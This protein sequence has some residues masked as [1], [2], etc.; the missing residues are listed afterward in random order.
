MAS[1]MRE[2]SLNT[3]THRLVV[4]TNKVLAAA[5]RGGVVRETILFLDLELIAPRALLHEV[6]KHIAS[7]ARRPGIDP[8]RLQRA[9]ATVLDRIK[10]EDPQLPYA[11]E[12]KRIASAFDPDDWPFIALALQFKAPIWTNDSKLIQA[13]LLTGAY[14]ALDTK[15]LHMLLRGEKLNKIHTYLREKYHV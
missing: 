10:L 15:A 1:R 4:D 5:L 2:K 9:L 3:D 12:A 6:R 13:S 11:L 14:L 7:I 8:G